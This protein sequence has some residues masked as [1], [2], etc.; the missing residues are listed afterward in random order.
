MKYSVSIIGKAEKQLNKLPIQIKRRIR[1]VILSLENNPYPEGCERIKGN[2]EYIRIVVGDYC[3][4]YTVKEKEL[5]VIIVRVCK[6][7]EAYRNIMQLKKLKLL[8]FLSI[9]ST[10]FFIRNMSRSVTSPSA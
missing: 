6:R 9:L 1:D 3:I 2:R 4:I 8:S 10:H 5:I 7:G